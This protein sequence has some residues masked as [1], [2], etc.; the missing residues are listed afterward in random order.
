MSS[1]HDRSHFES[2][3]AG[4]PPW[5]IGKPQAAIAE[6]VDLIISPVLDAGCARA[7]T[8]SSWRRADTRSP[9]SIS[10]R[11]QSA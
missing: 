4:K 6:S 10:S 3:Y 7:R 1:L 9:A 8:R 2:S 11:K 5:D